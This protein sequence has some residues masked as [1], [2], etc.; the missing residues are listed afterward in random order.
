MAPTSPTSRP[1]GRLAQ[2]LLVLWLAVVVVDGL[3]LWDQGRQWIDPV[4]D[5]TGLWQGPWNLF[6]P[7]VDKV[8]I[9]VGATIHFAD[10][11]ISQ[12]RSPEW[13]DMGAVDRFLKFREMEWVDGIRIDDNR[14]AW[15]SFAAY[16]AKQALHPRGANVPVARVRMTRYWAE[17]PPPERGVIPAEPYLQFRGARTFHEWTP[18]S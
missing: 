2:L 8:N 14:G 1:P 10:G 6:A 13:Q 3:P 12:W 17:I 18:P 4:L 16:L 11:Q 7:E 9:R 15:D 5:K